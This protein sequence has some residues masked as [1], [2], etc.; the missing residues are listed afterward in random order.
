[1]L[2][3]LCFSLAYD[4]WSILHDWI[5][6]GLI[7]TASVGAL[8]GARR[9]FPFLIRFTRGFLARHWRI[10]SGLTV[11]LILFRLAVPCPLRGNYVGSFTAHGCEERAF[12]RFAD[13]Q[14]TYFHG[15]L[16]PELKGKFERVGW[17]TYAWKYGT[18]TAYD[19]T[20][21][22]GWLFIRLSDGGYWLHRD[23]S[24]Q[25]DEMVERW[26]TNALNQSVEPTADCAFCFDL[27]SQAGGGSR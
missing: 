5:Q 22:A 17:N 8:I 26:M 12:L 1:M 7:A 13:G 27:E 19:T 4:D 3:G 21:T 24:F 11:L 20:I 10:L 6:L 14:I 18:N 15:S 2:L 23:L 16:Q 9:V 25:S